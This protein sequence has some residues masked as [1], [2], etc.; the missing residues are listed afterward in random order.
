MAV[1]WSRLLAIGL[2]TVGTAVLAAC[3]TTKAPS[4]HSSATTKATTTT[5]A[6]T[7]TPSCR[8]DQLVVFP[9]A[10]DVGAG[11]AGQQLGFLNISGSSCTL[12]GSPSVAFLNAAGMQVAEAK[13]A[14]SE[15]APAPLVTLAPGSA[16]ATIVQG[17]DGSVGNA[18]CATYPWFL[19]TPPGITQATPPGS[20]LSTKVAVGL[21][22]STTGFYVCGTPS[23]FPVGPVAATQTG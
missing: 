3:G 2:A 18:P 11:S 16:A 10:A 19:V 12:K 13:L 21:P 20:S 5:A 17:G 23:V 8:N 15:A 14:P 6:V 7:S 4:S 22:T 9:M 1:G